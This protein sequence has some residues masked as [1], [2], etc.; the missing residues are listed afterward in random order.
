MGQV[1]T[2][3]ESAPVPDVTPTALRAAPNPFDRSTKIQ[4]SLVTGGETRVMVYDVAGRRVREVHRGWLSPGRHTLPW[5]GLDDAGQPTSAGIY[6]VGVK[7][8]AGTVGSKV[9]RGSSSTRG[10]GAAG[11]VPPRHRCGSTIVAWR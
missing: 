5:D 4:L 10:R 8:P 3:V 2:A 7:T 9:Y 6:F 11:K 1:V